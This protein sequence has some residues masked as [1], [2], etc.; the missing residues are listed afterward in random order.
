MRATD[1]TATPPAARPVTT[2]STIHPI[3]SSATAA[4]M[5][6]EP[7]RVRKRSRSI[8]MRAITGIAEIDIAVA[9]NRANT[10]RPTAVGTS[11]S[12][13]TIPSANPA[14]NGRVK[15]PIQLPI[16]AARAL[17]RIPSRASRPPISTSITTPVHEK[18]SRRARWVGS[19][20]KRASNAFGAIQPSSEGPSMMP[21]TSSPTCS[22][23]P[24]R[25][26]SSPPSRAARKRTATSTRKRNS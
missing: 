24:I 16:T 7:V 8:R 9:R 14:A 11:A 18:T 12:G 26:A 10:G 6:T 15:P 23:M 2:E 20:G 25:A 4:A 17:A 21:N 19:A 1:P 3:V 13:N 5:I 22:G